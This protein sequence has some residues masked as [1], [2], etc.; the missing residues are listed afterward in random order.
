[1]NN[2]TCTEDKHETSHTNNKYNYMNT[3]KMHITWARTQAHNLSHS[4]MSCH[5]HLVVSVWVS[6]LVIHV[7][8]R[9]SLSSPLSSSTSTCPS[10]SSSF[11]STS[12]TSSCTLSSTI[13]SPCKACA[14]PRTRGVTT[15]TKSTPPSQC[16]WNMRFV[17]F[18]DRFQSTN[19]IG[20]NEKMADIQARSFVARILGGMRQ[21][22][23]LKEEQKWSNEKLLLDNALKLQGSVS[24]TWR[25]RN[26]RRPSRMLTR[27]WKHQLLLLCRANLWRRILGEVHLMWLK[28]NLRVCIF[29]A[30]ECT[31]L[32]M[33]ESLPT[34]HEDQIAGKGKNSLQHYNLV[35]KFYSFASSHENSRS[36]SSIG[37]GMGKIGELRCWI[38]RKSEVRK[39]WSMKQG[40]MAQK[41][42]SPHR[43]TSVIWKMLNWRQSTENTKV[44]L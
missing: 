25:T 40:Q 13:W 38:W 24:S 20:T 43:W 29:E 42:I 8:V 10:L 15:P 26:S 23:K 37:Q 31:R 3:R 7:H 44:E 18:M 30:C 33:G 11:P 32:R 22:A 1:M 5:M 36:N 35:H 41:F 17:R 9:L 21:N 14:T 39:R 4:L 12:C 28:Q 16:R 34:H 6:S 2:D 19:I 27:D